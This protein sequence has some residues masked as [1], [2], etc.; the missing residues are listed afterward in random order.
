MK[1][2]YLYI[3]STLVIGLTACTPQAIEQPGSEDI[4]ITAGVKPVAGI[5]AGTSRAA[6]QAI[7]YRG[8]NPADKPFMAEVWLS[9]TPGVYKH[10]PVTTGEAPTCLPIHTRITFDRNTPIFPPEYTPDGGGTSFKLKYPK[11]GSPAYGVGF[12]LNHKIDGSDDEY[13]H[14]SPMPWEIS[15]D[16]RTATHDIDGKTDL[17]VAPQVAGS[18]A[19]PFDTLR[20]HHV[21]TW[22]KLCVCATT[23][24]AVKDWGTITSIAVTSGKTVSVNLGAATV[25]KGAVTYTGTQSLTIAGNRPLTINVAEAGSLFCSPETE[26]T[27]TVTTANNTKTL[28]VPIRDKAGNAI[29]DIDRIRGRLFVINLFFKPYSVVEGVCTLNAWENQDEDLYPEYLITNMD[30]Q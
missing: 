13:A 24:E 25:D 30:N 22:L 5:E 17:M 21:Q 26:Y 28:T 1:R 11:N 23:E 15:A 10:A 12:Y 6:T 20:F 29:T 18:R 2:I 9:E 19:M 7:E 3:Y 16:G 8:I 27:L 14:A 4:S